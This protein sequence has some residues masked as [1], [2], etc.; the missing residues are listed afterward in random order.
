MRSDGHRPDASLRD[1]LPSTRPGYIVIALAILACKSEG[2][3]Q[4][5]EPRAY[6]ISPTGMNFGI[7]AFT[8]SAGDIGFDA[9]LPI[10]DANGVC[11]APFRIWALRGVWAIW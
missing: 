11:T 7:V 10:E 3:A 4:E 2:V 1:R 5:L 6:S 8:R 9:A